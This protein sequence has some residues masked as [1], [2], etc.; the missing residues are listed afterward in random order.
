MWICWGVRARDPGQHTTLP[1]PHPRP[2]LV[3]AAEAALRVAAH[4]QHALRPHWLHQ[5]RLA[6]G[7]QVAC[8]LEAPCKRA[9][10][11]RG[12][13]SMGKRLGST[14][15]KFLGEGASSAAASHRQRAA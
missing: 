9:M 15:R 4:H 1:Q 2:H 12:G 5:G 3:Q 11:G 10:K 7:R 14:A 8:E 6:V 13:A